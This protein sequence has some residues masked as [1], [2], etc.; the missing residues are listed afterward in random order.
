VLVSFVPLVHALRERGVKL[1]ESDTE[2]ARLII[3]FDH[4]LGRV[5]DV[6]VLILQGHLDFEDHV[7]SVALTVTIS[8][9]PIGEAIFAAMLW[10]LVVLL[11]LFL[12]LGLAVSHLLLLGILVVLLLVFFNRGRL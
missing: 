1:G 6:A 5:A 3:G 11:I 7:T 4:R 12:F 10:L 2:A 9:A 8:Q